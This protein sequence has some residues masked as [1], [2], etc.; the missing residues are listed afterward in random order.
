MSAALG[1]CRRYREGIL[2]NNDSL[3]VFR[4]YS[5][6]TCFKQ[7][8]IIESFYFKRKSKKTIRTTETLILSEL[9]HRDFNI[10]HYFS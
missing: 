10:I 1:H 5:L 3:K 8:R 2:I 7:Y 4:E 9:D 6:D